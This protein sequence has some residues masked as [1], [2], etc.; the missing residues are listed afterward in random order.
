M[1]ADNNIAF[2][3]RLK[4]G[5][6]SAFSELF[7][8]SFSR[9]AA[10]AAKFVDDEAALDIVQDVFLYLWEKRESVQFSGTIYSYL[11]KAVHNACVN[12]IKHGKVKNRH[13]AELDIKSKKLDMH[14]DSDNNEVI[15]NLI[16]NDL[17]KKITERI[18]LLP[19][20]CREVF[21]MS[22]LSDMKSSEIGEMLGISQR[23]VESHL[24]KALKILREYF[25]N[26]RLILFLFGTKG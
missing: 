11:F 10:Y 17:N 22:Y 14:Y 8:M 23:T 4:E 2:F 9:L 26:H 21:E 5:D 20:K 1:L 15:E 12:H 18:G 3:D 24:Y 6:R 16:A 25:S 13:A 7:E 19:D